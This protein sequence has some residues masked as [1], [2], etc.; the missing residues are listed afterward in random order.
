ME[1]AKE[2]AADA[3]HDVTDTSTARCAPNDDFALRA[4]GPGTWGNKLYVSVDK[5]GIT[6]EVGERYGLASGAPLFNLS[7]FNDPA[8]DDGG[9]P[10]QP[11]DERIVNVTLYAGTGERRLDR[12]LDRLSNLVRSDVSTFIAAEA[13]AGGDTVPISVAELGTAVAFEGGWNSLPLTDESYVGSELDKTGIHGLDDVD[14]INILCIPPDVRGGDTSAAV[15]NNTLRYCVA[16]RAMLIVDPPADWTNRVLL[17]ADPAARLRDDVQLS[18]PAARNAFL[19]YPRVRMPD[20]AAGGALDTFP[21]CGIIAGLFARNNGT[22]GVWIAPAGLE[23]A[24]QRRRPRSPAHRPRERNPEPGR[25]QLPAVVP[26]SPGTV[27]VGGADAPRRRPARRRVQVPPRPPHGALP[28][29]EP[30]PRHAVGGL[31][32]QRRAA[33]GARSGSTSG[34]S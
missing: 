10:T 12:V 7:I 14:L 20:L 26:P 32:T 28:R 27:P 24:L 31:P 11:P 15:Y 30:V 1:Q 2:A 18:G 33:V 29:G 25:D 16:R 22:R 8:L 21:A 13:D 34:P 5:I 3:A 4:T 9:Q 6:D 19:Y 17:L 23:A